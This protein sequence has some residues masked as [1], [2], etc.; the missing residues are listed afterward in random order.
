M[1]DQRRTQEERY[2]MAP[3]HNMDTKEQLVLSRQ[4]HM[5]NQ[6]HLQNLQHLQYLQQVHQELVR[7]QH[8]MMQTVPRSV[9]IGVPQKRKGP[10]KIKT[11][12]MVPAANIHAVDRW[13]WRKYGQ[14][15]IKDATFPRSYYKCSS[16]KEC[17]AR[18]QVEMCKLEPEIYLVTYIG[19]HIHP[20]PIQPAQMPESILASLFP[21]VPPQ[22]NIPL[23][24]LHQQPEIFSSEPFK[25]PEA[26][27][28]LSETTLVP[29]E[30]PLKS[31][32]IPT[33]S[34][35]MSAPIEK[36]VEDLLIPNMSKFV[37][38]DTWGAMEE[39]EMWKN[40]NS[41][42]E[43]GSGIG[44]DSFGTTLK[45]WNNKNVDDSG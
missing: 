23:F 12:Y 14:K 2:I 26:P 33:I 1:V 39:L 17:N 3:M 8:P 35:I 22:S 43:P 15:P 34:E 44:F 25:L 19:D 5:Q 41:N 28:M 45:N 37:D 42:Y 30:I 4:T 9:K 32:K 29:E 20:S 7:E 36:E 21:P 24:Q 18:K 40:W 16:S 38:E 6:Q 31:S 27:S 11:V 10:S 13:A